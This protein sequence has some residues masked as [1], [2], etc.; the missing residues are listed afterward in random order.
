MV[1]LVNFRIS[2]KYNVE[3]R[4]TYSDIQLNVNFFNSAIARELHAE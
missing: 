4:N 1:G 3:R 2:F